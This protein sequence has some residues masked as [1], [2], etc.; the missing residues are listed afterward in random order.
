MRVEESI[1]KPTNDGGWISTSDTDNCR[2]RKAAVSFLALSP[3]S[4]K[5]CNIAAR[6]SHFVRPERLPTV[7]ERSPSVVH[8]QIGSHHSLKTKTKANLNS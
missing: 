5:A 8:F 7:D 1:E 4:P 3:L 2:T 6:N